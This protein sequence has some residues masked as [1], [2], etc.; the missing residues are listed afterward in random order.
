MGV[1]W[2]EMSEVWWGRV[3]RGIVDKFLDLKGEVKPRGPFLHLI[4]K[5]YINL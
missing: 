5:V 3:I 1:E 4:L 2:G